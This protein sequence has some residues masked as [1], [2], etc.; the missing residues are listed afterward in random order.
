[1]VS[2]WFLAGSQCRVTM[3]REERKIIAVTTAGHGL[4]HGFILIFSA[5]LPMFLQ[6]FG[7]DYFH[8]RLVGNMCFLAFGLG[9]PPEG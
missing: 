4:N 8:L 5:V 7:T 2:M 9:S 1:M 6:D 3:T